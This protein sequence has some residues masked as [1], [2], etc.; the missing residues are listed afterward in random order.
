MITNKKVEF[1][2]R[3]LLLLE[4]H[5][6]VPIDN[7]IFDVEVTEEIQAI[8]NM[9]GMKLN[10]EEL[11]EYLLL[12]EP[13]KLSVDL[14]VN[15][16]LLDALGVGKKKNDDTTIDTDAKVEVKFFKE[17][18]KEFRDYC[19]GVLHMSKSELLSYTPVEI[20]AILDAHQGHIKYMYNLNKIAHINAIGLTKSKK[21]KEINPFDNTSD[22]KF[23]K[24][25]LEKKK[26]DLDFLL[27]KVGE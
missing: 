13:L 26:A 24:V 9:F 22:K 5:I 15:G 12:E 3:T 16:A 23:K 1:D 27:N 6:N 7:L 4:E 20:Y 21:F 11:K 2:I 17:Y 18:I 14:K 10:E 8:V 19:V 25:S